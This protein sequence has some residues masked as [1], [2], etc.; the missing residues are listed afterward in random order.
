MKRVLVTGATSMIG[1]ALINELI[2]KN[3]EKLSELPNN[4]H[5]E[6]IECNM[7]D[8]GKLN[9]LISGNID[10]AFAGAWSGTRGVLRN[11]VELQADNLKWNIELLN[12]VIN[13]GCTKFLTAGSQAEYGLWN[14]KEK[15]TE[16]IETKPINEYGINKLKFYE[17]AV[18]YCTEHN[19]KL[20]EPRFFSLYG[21]KDLSG[22]LIISTLE[23]LLKNEIC[24]LTECVQ[25][26]DFMYIDDA[27]KALC[28]L[29]ENPD[30][31]GIYNFGSGYSAPLTEYIYKMKEITN[32]SSILNF[33]AI[34][35]PKEVIVNVNPDVTRL[36]NLGWNCEISFERGIMEIIN[37]MNKKKLENE[38]VERRVTLVFKHN[39]ISS[40]GRYAA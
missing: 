34:P 33:G 10:I 25:I 7:S 17:Y 12:S 13:M 29:I 3:C 6:I 31:G 22:T 27:V 32:S 8:F 4:D 1:S 11:D 20:I 40:K 28:M 39:S 21:P 16:E 38:G 26:W 23:K 19:C 5:V 15:I 2:R 9:E 35:Y 36:H 18:K 24:D 30:S 14:K 37:Y